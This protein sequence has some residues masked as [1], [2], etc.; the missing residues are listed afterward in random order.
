LADIVNVP[1]DAATHDALADCHLQI[2]GVKRGLKQLNVT[3]FTRK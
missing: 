3:A 1:L 2:L